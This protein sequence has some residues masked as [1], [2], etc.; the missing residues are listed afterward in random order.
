MRIRAGLA[1]TAAW[2]V[3]ATAF[4]ALGASFGL[5]GADLKAYRPL[6]LQIAGAA[7]VLMGIALLVLSSGAARPANWD[8]APHAG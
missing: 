6:L 7:L 5:I 3:F 8:H 1:Q 4:V 2:S